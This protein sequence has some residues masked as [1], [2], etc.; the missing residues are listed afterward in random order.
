VDHGVADV[1]VDLNIH[2]SLG[3]ETGVL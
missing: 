3:Y 1:T 2:A